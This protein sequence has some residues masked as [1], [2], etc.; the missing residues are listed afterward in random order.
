MAG[1]SAFTKERK[2]GVVAPPEEGPAHTRFALSVDSVSAKVPEVVSGEPEIAN[3]VGT[4]IVTEVTVPLPTVSV[5][6]ENNPV[7]VVKA[8]AVDADT[9]LGI[10]VATHAV[11]EDT[12][13]VF[14]AAVERVVP[15]FAKGSTPVTSVVSTI[16]AAIES[17]ERR[18]AAE[19]ESCEVVIPE[20]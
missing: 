20:S 8:N 11:P 13:V 17:C 1:R 14:A 15:P 5:W 7:A 12:S 19:A 10:A 4:V 16:P 6:Q 9:Q 3:P 2:V 18:I